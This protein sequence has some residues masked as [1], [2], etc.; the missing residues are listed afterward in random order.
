MSIITY[1]LT[2]YGITAVISLLTVA[3]ILVVNS[4][5]SKSDKQNGDS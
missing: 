4:L 5:M 1:A 3:V 2:A